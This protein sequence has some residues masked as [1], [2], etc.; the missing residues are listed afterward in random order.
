[1]T[2]AQSPSAVSSETADEQVNSHKIRDMLKEIGHH[3]PSQ[4]PLDFFVHH[5]TLH[6]FEDVAFKEA[7]QQADA[8]LGTHSLMQESAY[9]DNFQKGRIRLDDLNIILNIT[10]DQYTD[11]VG[12]S[13]YLEQPVLLRH[14]ILRYG[15]QTPSPG[16]I[17]WRL[18]DQE[19]LQRFPQALERR[20]QDH[21]TS[22]FQIMWNSL[23]TQG[24]STKCWE[25]LTGEQAPHTTVRLMAGYYRHSST[26]IDEVD[27]WIYD[28]PT[29]YALTS[30]WLQCMHWIYPIS[31]RCEQKELA[32]RHRDVLLARCGEDLDDLTHPVVLRFFS[33][34]CDQGMSYWPMPER[35]QGLLKSFVGLYYQPLTPLPRW[36]NKAVS[37]LRQAL[38]SSQ[39]PEDVLTL[40]LD[41]LQI[42]PEHQETYLGSVLLSLR[43]WMGMIQKLEQRPDYLVNPTHIPSL[44]EAA[45]LQ[46]TLEWAAWSTYLEEHPEQTWMLNSWEQQLALMPSTKKDWLVDCYRLF[47]V[48]LYA[49]I[50]TEEFFVASEEQRLQLWGHIEQFDTFSRC[51]LWHLAY[52]RHYCQQIL[53]GLQANVKENSTLP[54][55]SDRPQFQLVCCIDE[56]EES[57]R[58]HVE[59]IEPACK[60]LGAAGFFGMDMN[61]QGKHDAHARA[62]CPPVVFPKRYVY[63]KPKAS[64]QTPEEQQWQSIQRRRRLWGWLLRHGFV[65]SRSLVRGFVWSLLVG[66]LNIVPMLLRILVPQKARKLQQMFH[67]YLSPPVATY[68]TFLLEESLPEKPVGFTQDELVTRATTMLRLM[69]LTSNFAPLVLVMGHGSTSLNN[70]HEAA[71]DCGA[72]GGG[73]GGP[74]ARVFASTLNLPEIRERLRHESHI[75]IPQDTWFLGTFHDTC[76]DA[77]DYYELE[78]LPSS[79]Q[80]QFEHVRRV[81]E[82][83]RQRNAHERCRRFESVP[84]TLTPLQALRHVEGRSQDLS[85]PRPEYGHATNAICIV[86]RREMTR[87]LYLDRRAFLVSYDPTQDSELNHLSALLGA[88]GPVCVGINLEYFFSFVNNQFYGCGTKLP[89]NISGYL[90]VINGNLSDLQPGLPWQM[91]EI[92]EP[93]RL[94]MIIEQTPD[95]FKRVLENQPYFAKLVRNH[96]LFVVTIDPVTRA[97]SFW[98]DHDL[99]PWVVPEKQLLSVLQ[100]GIW[101]RGKR[102]HLEP[103]RV[104]ASLPSQNKATAPAVG[105]PDGLS[106]SP[107][108]SS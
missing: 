27:S 105:H 20:I 5:N 14:L 80:A 63:E 75:D 64:P 100:S 58:R 103:A 72:C 40:A 101:Y 1:M 98:Q 12:L 19:E 44:V 76:S 6:A 89:H 66:L 88:V 7:L 28:N 69:G 21:H 51:W 10:P 68:T 59:E 60:T 2:E 43:G 29:Q 85:E 39:T 71:H 48:C 91:V 47:Q 4:L 31:S 62:L 45:A 87:G 86:G 82:L 67:Y 22:R 33:Q 30:L 90:G 93:V 49:G 73:R 107:A 70:P 53:A 99:V 38:D 108:R 42:E 26:S 17:H 104:L 13:G 56:R 92:H 79:H 9:F 96:W 106:F 25:F 50:S 11:R 3:L 77:I 16:V 54:P 46:M 78:H 18:F 65:G 61:Y 95:N 34:Y 37:T 35:E 24:N 41:R 57:L 84:L 97:F 81:L 8:L 74:N 94:L 83:A 36:L 52:E 15:L 102:D 32:H 55:D 23:R